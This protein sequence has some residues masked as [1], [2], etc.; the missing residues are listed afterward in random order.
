[1][2]IP[3]YDSMKKKSINEVESYQLASEGPH[4]YLAYRDI[5]KLITSDS[6]GTKALDYG[7]G[8]GASTAYVQSLGFQTVG[9]DVSVEMVKL[10]TQSFPDNRF[11]LSHG[12]SIPFENES[13]GFVFSCFVLFE[14]KSH[15]QIKTYLKE[16]RRVL[17]KDGVLLIITGGEQMYSRDW[18]IFGTNY[19]ENANLLSGQK[20]K[21]LLRQANM[22]FVDYFW[23]EAD[24]EKCFL[25]SKFQIVQKHYPLGNDNEPFPWKDERYTSPFIIYKLQCLG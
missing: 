24:Y 5:P 20:A 7:C 9:V 23:K 6:I 15:A 17:R 16:A 1:M 11:Y 2:D 19:P 22:E 13:F 12:S 8:T 10:A 21:V 3:V 14:L 4:R 18:L 25:E